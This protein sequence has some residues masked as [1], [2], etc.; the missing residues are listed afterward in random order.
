[1]RKRIIQAEALITLAS[2]V[3]AVRCRNH[4]ASSCLRA[5]QLIE[6]LAD[7]RARRQLEVW[8]RHHARREQRRRAALTFQASYLSSAPAYWNNDYFDDF[9]LHNGQLRQYPG[10][11]TDVFFDEAMRWIKERGASG[12]PFFALISPNT[13]HTPLFVPQQYREPY[14]VSPTTRPASSG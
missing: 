13:P 5:P 2:E 9:Y 6:E 11:C 14:A 8:R 3:G 10:Y 1:M 7:P 12:E 4:R